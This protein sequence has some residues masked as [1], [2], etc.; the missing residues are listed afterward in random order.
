MRRTSAGILPPNIGSVGGCQDRGTSAVQLISTTA[1]GSNNSVTTTAV[2]AGY[3]TRAQFGVLAL[4]APF[5]QL[6][7]R[8][9]IGIPGGRCNS[10]RGH[11]SSAWLGP[12]EEAI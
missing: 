3:A 5:D 10:G 12:R 7:D 4:L 6:R 11:G 2:Q 1:S 9:L 8:G